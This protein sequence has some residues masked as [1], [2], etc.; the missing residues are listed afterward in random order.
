[1]AINAK[2]INSQ[3]LNAEGQ[4]AHFSSE[5]YSAF[6]I[7]ATQA[8]V[9]VVHPAQA[10]SIVSISQSTTG[11][12]VLRPL[13][14]VVI[15][16]TADPL[17]SLHTHGFRGDGVYGF[18][19]LQ[20]IGD[21]LMNAGNQFATTSIVTVSALPIEE[22][23]LS[24]TGFTATIDAIRTQRARGQSALDISVADS[25]LPTIFR[26]MYA[27]SI[28]VVKSDAEP[29]VNRDHQSTATSAFG[30][31]SD[32][33]EV[34]VRNNS[35]GDADIRILSS[36]VDAGVNV[37]HAGRIHSTYGFNS[38]GSF[39]V[40]SMIEATSTFRVSTNS[41]IWTRI[42]Q[43]HSTRSMG[44]DSRRAESSVLRGMEIFPIFG[45]FSNLANGAAWQGFRAIGTIRIDQ[46]TLARRMVRPV[47]NS[48]ISITA[49]NANNLTKH[50][51]F[52]PASA[53]SQF[54][55]LTARAQPLSNLT[56]PAADCNTFVVSAREFLFEVPFEDRRFVVP[57]D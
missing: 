10:S 52:H 5:A 7:E 51:T 35:L 47:A 2:A 29:G 18:K 37:K 50:Y 42:R 17:Q 4:T 40:N 31:T 19:S 1:M 38:T 44:L 21:H 56:Q 32:V 6:S 53:F 26:Q 24:F 55:V 36:V 54:D 8:R 39:Y 22:V 27:D 11:T 28:A 57:C 48:S 15:S 14:D 20:I 16:I 25:T 33:P 3:A 30:F 12:R 23:T 13:S 41:A 46:T 43:V 34:L 49:I 9:T 45:F